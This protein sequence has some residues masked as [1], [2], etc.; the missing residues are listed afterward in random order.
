MMKTKLNWGEGLMIGMAAFMTFIVILG[1]QMFRQSPGDYD[2]H[3]YEKGLAFDSVYNKEKQVITDGAEPHFKIEN[4]TL[5]VQFANESA[6]KI[7]FER[8]SDPDL[9][10]VIS[11]RSGVSNLAII[12]IEKFATGQWQL[13][14]EWESND[15][16]YLYQREMYLP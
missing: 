5:H 15:K 13:T 4:K 10:K 8:P 2:H 14:F 1:V 6:G 12:P 7:R 9:D 16:K 11:F 3:Y